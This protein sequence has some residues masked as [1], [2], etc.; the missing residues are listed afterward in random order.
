MA[1]SPQICISSVSGIHSSTWSIKHTRP[2]GTQHLLQLLRPPD[3]LSR[4]V[5]ANQPIPAPSQGQ[6][7]QSSISSDSEAG[8]G[9]R[10]R[11]ARR[12]PQMQPAAFLRR[13]AHAQGSARGVC[14]RVDLALCLH[15]WPLE[16]AFV[17]KLHALGL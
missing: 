3:W 5:G 7:N 2:R 6:D 1:K 16:S 13:C 4:G 8:L 9:R 11:K 14:F 17:G 12:P 10:R 15:C